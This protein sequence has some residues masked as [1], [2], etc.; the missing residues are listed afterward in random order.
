MAPSMLKGMQV[1]AQH[2]LPSRQ[3]LFKGRP[4]IFPQH[5]AKPH[6]ASITTAWLH[7]RRVQG[8]ELACLQSRPF[9]N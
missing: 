7:S 4:C 1:L 6:T 5:D 2:M 9:I 3:H 8:A